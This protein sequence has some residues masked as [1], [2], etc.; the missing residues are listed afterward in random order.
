MNGKISTP[1]FLGFTALLV[2]LSLSGC[3]IDATPTDTT[4]CADQRYVSVQWEVVKNVNG[5]SLSCDQAN[6][7]TVVMDFGP[8]TWSWLCSDYADTSPTSGLPEGSYSTQMQLLDPGGVVLSTTPVA[9]YSIFHCQPTYVSASF[10]V[11]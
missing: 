9:T 2:T 3:I 4:T 10:G 11:N 5:A 6:A 1:V 7:S 8:Y